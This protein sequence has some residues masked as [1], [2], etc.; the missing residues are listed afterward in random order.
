VHECAKACSTLSICFD[1]RFILQRTCA[2]VCVC[3]CGLSRDLPLDKEGS[4]N[5]AKYMLGICYLLTSI[6]SMRRVNLA[7]ETYYRG[8]RDLL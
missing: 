5:K 2:C 7:N 4:L 1:T 3:V 8:K 6:S